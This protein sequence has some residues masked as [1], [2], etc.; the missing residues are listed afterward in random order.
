MLLSTV[1]LG[2]CFVF[3]C[4]YFFV[5]FIFYFLWGEVCLLLSFCC[6]SR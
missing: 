6:Y 5:L 3:V 1:Y 2:L 4:F